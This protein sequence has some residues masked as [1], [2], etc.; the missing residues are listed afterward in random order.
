MI[1]KNT[2]NNGGTETEQIL[3]RKEKT[4]TYLSHWYIDISVPTSRHCEKS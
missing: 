1:I 2:T 3:V 4:E